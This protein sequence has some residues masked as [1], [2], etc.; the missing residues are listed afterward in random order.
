MIQLN[1]TILINKLEHYGIRGTSLNWFSSYLTE[2]T[3][4]TFCNN[5]SSEFKNITCGVPQGSV[6]G[7][8]LF[9]LYIN[10]LPNISQKLKFYLFAD[11]TNIFYQN[12]NLDN[13]QAVLNN[14]LK[15]LSIWLNANR[16]ALNI[17]KTNFVIFAPKNKPLKNVTLL[18]NKKAIQQKDHV[19]Y[20]GVLIDSQLTF[21]YHIT[22]VSKKISR[23]TGLM[24]RIRKYVDNKTLTMIYY[25][26]IYPYLIYGIP[27]W[28]NADN[29]HLNSIFTI[30]KKLY[31]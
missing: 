30:Q 7:P 2:R 16:L 28:G 8:L 15:K 9:L 1:H 10:D 11:D 3:Q 6:L 14:E 18:I 23:T 5:K 24:Y 12:S 31:E 22:A 4:Y 27:I 21:K 20:L 25:S 13:L 26:L 19:K 29:V 17:S